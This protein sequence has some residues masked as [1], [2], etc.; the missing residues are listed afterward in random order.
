ME[1]GSTRPS[2]MTAPASGSAAPLFTR[3]ST[4]L[5]RD[6]TGRQSIALNFIGGMPPIGIAFGIFF[7]LSGFPAGHLLLGIL[8]ALPLALA[9]SYS[10]GLLSAV[11]PRSGGDY[12]LVSRI[13]TPAL[14]LISSCCMLLAVLLAAATLAVAF[15]T[16]GI[17]PGLSTLGYVANSNTLVEWGNTV[18]TSKNWQFM[19]GGVLM[20]LA[21]ALILTAGW[22]WTKR[23]V[24]AMLTFSLL[25]LGVTCLIAL[26]T[27]HGSFVSHFDS[28]AAKYTDSHHAYADT[29]AA[30]R[31]S[32]IPVGA[33][34]SLKNSFPLIGVMALFGIYSYTTAFLAGEI[35]QASTTKTGHRMA[36]EPAAA[37][38]R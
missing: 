17:A 19:L 29:I 15:P 24:I 11:I 5:V 36:A 33:G 9:Y 6:V 30:A 34:F 1:A 7:A 10:F 13:L 14:G 31:K 25:G 37:A 22:R 16:Q 8:L 3:R 4:G 18:A 27:S 32:A 21:C 2:P 28:F 38:K 35:R 20:L 23:A 26:F 12:V